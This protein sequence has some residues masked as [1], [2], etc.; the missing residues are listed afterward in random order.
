M[1]EQDAPRVVPVFKGWYNSGRVPHFDSGHCY[2]MLTFRLADALPQTVLRGLREEVRRVPAVQRKGYSRQRIE[3]WLDQGMGSCLLAHSGLAAALAEAFMHFDGRRYQLVAWCIMPNHVHVLIEQ[4][5]SLSRI[6]QGWKS[7]SSRWA[8]EQ[9][10]V[11]GMSVSGRALW[12]RG[13]W[14]RFVRD[15]SHFIAAVTYIHNNPVK[16]GL[17]K[18]AD[19]WRWSSAYSGGRS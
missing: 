15:E 3:F 9:G 19:E 1:S 5:F 11:V 14:D 4:R 2:Q 12:M 7:R 6:V 17:C 10:L 16:A 8:L 13:Y 18:S